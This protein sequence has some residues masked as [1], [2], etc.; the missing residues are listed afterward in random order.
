KFRRVLFR[1]QKLIMLFMKKFLIA[2]RKKSLNWLS[3]IK[4]KL[5]IDYIPIWKKNGSR[6]IM[7]TSGEMH[8]RNPGTLA[9]GVLKRP[10]S[11]KYYNLMMKVLKIIFIITMT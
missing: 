2:T 4:K 9:F 3:Q 7:T 11:Q 8:T 5:Q 10:Q 1:S 6:G